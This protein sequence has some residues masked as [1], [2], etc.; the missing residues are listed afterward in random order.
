M[1]HGCFHTLADPLCCSSLCCARRVLQSELEAA[2]AAQSAVEAGCDHLASTIKDLQAELLSAL[3]SNRVRPR[4]VCPAT[5]VMSWSSSH[6]HVLL[7]HCNIL[8][9][10]LT[11][12]WL[13][14]PT[15]TLC[16][17]AY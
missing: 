14:A 17:T 6:R 4:A 1:N 11:A 7:S 2:L 3:Q 16:S 12:T 15:A 8:L 10:V 5:G 13:T 9:P